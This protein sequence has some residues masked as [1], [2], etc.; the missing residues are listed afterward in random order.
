MDIYVSK[1]EIINFF[2]NSH[3]YLILRFEPLILQHLIFII[4]FEKLKI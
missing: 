4:E 2:L 3:I 1:I